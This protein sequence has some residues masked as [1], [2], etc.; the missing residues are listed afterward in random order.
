MLR[1]RPQIGLIRLIHVDLK[2]GI[3]LERGT[4]RSGNFE[5]LFSLKISALTYKPERFQHE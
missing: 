2:K 1:N 4:L 3:E 5:T